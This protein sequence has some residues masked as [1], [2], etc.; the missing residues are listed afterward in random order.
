MTLHPAVEPVVIPLHGTPCAICTRPAH[1]VTAT[2]R[3]I[4]EVRTAPCIGLPPL[5][6]TR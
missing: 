5:V 6:V 2:G 4:H 1:G 3:V